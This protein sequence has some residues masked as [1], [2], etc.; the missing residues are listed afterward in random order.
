MKRIKINTKLIFLIPSG[1]FTACGKDQRGFMSL[2]KEFDSNKVK[3]C[4]GIF[5]IN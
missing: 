2:S 3:M 1:N 4:K 5:R